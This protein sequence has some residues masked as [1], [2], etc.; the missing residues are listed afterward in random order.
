MPTGEGEYRPRTAFRGDRG[1]FRGRG[2]ARGRGGSQDQRP[3]REFERQS[4]SDK[5]G[6]KSV[7]KREGGGSHNWGS[8]QDEIEGQLEPTTV[9]EVAEAEGE[10][11]QT[12]AGEVK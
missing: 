3:R 7:E 12:E 1:G 8:V 6:V 9:E 5:S 4:G 2:R 10:A 11:P